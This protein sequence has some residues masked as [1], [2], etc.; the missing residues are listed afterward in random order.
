MRSAAWGRTQA[1]SSAMPAVVLAKRRRRPAGRTWTSRWS[2]ETSM[3]MNVR[4]IGRSPEREKELRAKPA[5]FLFQ[6]VNAACVQVTI[7]TKA[8]RQEA[9]PYFGSDSRGPSVRRSR[10]PFGFVFHCPV[11]SG[12]RVDENNIPAE[13]E[14]LAPHLADCRACEAAV[15][16]LEQKSDPVIAGLRRH[17]EGTD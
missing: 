14:K 6:L 13:L 11:S 8:R 3:P 9:D 4:S 5:P 17:P 15:Q 7:R 12:H 1:R 2:W 16:A 10:P